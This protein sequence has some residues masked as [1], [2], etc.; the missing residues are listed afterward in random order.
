MIVGGGFTA[1]DCARAARRILGQ[2]N[3]VTAIMYRRGEEHMSASPEEIWQLRL[4]G[5]EIG[6]LANPQSVRFE[7]GK[8]RCCRLQPQHP[9]R[10]ARWQRKA[11][12][13]SQSRTASTRYPATL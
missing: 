3:R 4:E 13:H 1:I 9:G 11:A 12:R 7:D 6:T 10:C 2:K 5:I 8:V